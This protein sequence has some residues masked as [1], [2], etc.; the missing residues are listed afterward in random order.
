MWSESS[1]LSTVNLEKKIY[2][3]SRDI[4]FFLGGYFFMARPVCQLA[5]VRRLLTLSS[6]HCLITY[7]ISQRACHSSST[8]S[9]SVSTGKDIMI[10]LQVQTGPRQ[11]TQRDV[12]L[13]ISHATHTPVYTPWRVICFVCCQCTVSS[14]RIRRRITA[15]SRWSVGSCGEAPPFNRCAR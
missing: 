9:S 3:S 2:Y 1:T 10:N 8:S 13:T 6:L 15:S 5:T 12:I 7:L 11:N 14:D 4:E